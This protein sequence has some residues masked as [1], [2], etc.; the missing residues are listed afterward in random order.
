MT[1]VAYHIQSKIIFMISK[2]IENGIILKSESKLANHPERIYLY[3]NK[4]I[5][6]DMDKVWEN[7][8]ERERAAWE[9]G[10]KKQR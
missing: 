5:S 2:I 7:K 9:S 1:T 4:D 3:L 10:D 6:K 8:R